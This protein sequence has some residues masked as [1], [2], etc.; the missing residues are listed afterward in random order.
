MRDYMVFIPVVGRN[1]EV[2]ST[3]EELSYHKIEARGN[4][5]CN[6]TRT[7]AQLQSKLISVLMMVTGKQ[8]IKN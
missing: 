8:C 2:E 7:G 3:C 6:L 5:T 4:Q 1:E